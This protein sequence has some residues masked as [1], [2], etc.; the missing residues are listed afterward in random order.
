VKKETTPLV[1]PP[2][3]FLTHT[4]H[5][6]FAFSLIKTPNF[7]VNIHADDIGRSFN[8]LIATDKTS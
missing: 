4:N 7:V 3:I 8:S 1:N 2:G 5:K 6:P